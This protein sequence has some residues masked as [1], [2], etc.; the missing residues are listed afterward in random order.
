MKEPDIFLISP[1]EPWWD[2]IKTWKMVLCMLFH[3]RESKIWYNTHNCIIILQVDEYKGNTIQQMLYCAKS[4]F[5][6]YNDPIMG[7]RQ[8]GQ[9]GYLYI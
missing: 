5:V 3:S 7:L 9:M 1:D 8:D 4:H 6:A 2:F